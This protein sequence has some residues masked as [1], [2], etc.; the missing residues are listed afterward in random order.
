[1]IETKQTLRSDQLSGLKAKLAFLKS[2]EDPPEVVMFDG[3][4]WVFE[5]KSNSFYCVVDENSPE[6]GELYDAG[7]LLI[8]LS[9]VAVE[10]DAL[11]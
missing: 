9:G 2:C 11:Y 3:A 7:V 10:E 8:E 1:M 4:Q 6:A 5:H